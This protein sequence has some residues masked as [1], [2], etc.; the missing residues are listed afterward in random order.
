LSACAQPICHNLL[1]FAPVCA[2]EYKERG[3]VSPK[4]DSFSFAVVL[5]ELVTGKD[6]LEAMSLHMDEAELFEELHQYADARAGAWPGGVVAEL[7][8][9]AEQCIAYHV[10]RRAFVSDMVP[11][12]DALAQ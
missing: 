12:L 5:L 8:A 4:T 6:G 11:R 1:C 3:H 7:A 2:Q 10:S 9:V